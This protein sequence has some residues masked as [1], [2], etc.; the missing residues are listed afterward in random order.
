MTTMHGPPPGSPGPDDLKLE[1]CEEEMLGY[2]EIGDPMDRYKGP[3][4]LLTMPDWG[5]ERTIRAAVLRQ[6][7]VSQKWPVHAR[8]VKLRGLRISGPLDLEAAILRCPLHLD[9]CYLEDP[10]PAIL[11]HAAVSL[12][13]LSNCRLT[14][15]YGDSLTVTKDLDLT[16]SKFAG[17]LLLPR[18]EITGSLTCTGAQLEPGPGGSAL[19]ANWYSSDT[20]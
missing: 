18:A 20:S 15:L 6:L 1:P 7:L 12:L 11:N 10:G 19:A 2:A 3:S 8:G 13:T 5:S 4:D 16:G 14:G 17:P 9:Y